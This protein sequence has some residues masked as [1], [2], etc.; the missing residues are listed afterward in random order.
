MQQS[1]ARLKGEFTLTTYAYCTYRSHHQGCCLMSGYKNQPSARFDSM[2]T[3]L[4]HACATTT[5]TQCHDLCT[6]SQHFTVSI[7]NVALLT[8]SR[9]MK[10]GTAT[11]ALI[12]ARDPD[13]GWSPLHFAARQGHAAAVEWLIASA[14]AFVGA[15][16]PEGYTPLHLA[17]GTLKLTKTALLLSIQ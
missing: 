1:M 3:T 2:S 12:D 15:C 10:L 4:Q 5:Y 7:G 16:G 17:A 14:N 11:P 9:L 6:D 13:T 8:V